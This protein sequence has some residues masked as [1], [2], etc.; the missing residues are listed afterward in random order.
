MTNI[1][2]YS[3]TSSQ[4]YTTLPHVDGLAFEKQPVPFLIIGRIF[5]MRQAKYIGRYEELDFEPLTSEC[6]REIVLCGLPV[7]L[8]S[9]R[10]KHRDR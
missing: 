7:G 10:Q 4:I 1:S 9:G 3:K 6:F 5:K 8:A 2:G